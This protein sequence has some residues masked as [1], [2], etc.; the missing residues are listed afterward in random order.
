MTDRFADGTHAEYDQDSF[1]VVKVGADRRTTAV[2][3]Y[4]LDITNSD[5]G[6]GN[7]QFTITGLP[8]L[9]A[10]EKYEISYT[11]TPENSSGGTARPA[12]ATRSVS[13]PR[14]AATAQ[15]ERSGHLPTDAE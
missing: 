9:E 11:A 14:A 10:G 5:W 3:G 6:G 8:E 7:K 2:S 13:P 12:S 4:Q 15:L 1:S